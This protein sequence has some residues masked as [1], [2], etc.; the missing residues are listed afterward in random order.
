MMLMLML[1]VRELVLV[2]VLVLVKTGTE[3]RERRFGRPVHRAS[4]RSRRGL[5]EAKEKKRKEKRK[6]AQSASETQKTEGRAS[7]K[8][9]WKR[10]KTDSD[11]EVLV[12]VVMSHRC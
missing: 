2:L 12:V 3:E 8:D 9:G 4:E 5:Y 1:M 11:Q 6:K 7:P 10:R